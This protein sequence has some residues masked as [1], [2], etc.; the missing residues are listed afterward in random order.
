MVGGPGL[1][2]GEEKQVGIEMKLRIQ[3]VQ[4]HPKSDSGHETPK[5]NQS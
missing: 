3:D 4:I 1:K 5:L 2:G